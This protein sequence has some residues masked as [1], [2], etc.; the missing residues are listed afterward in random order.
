MHYVLIRYK[1]SA[2]SQE[3]DIAVT[4][5]QPRALQH[6]DALKKLYPSYQNGEFIYK[7]I[8]LIK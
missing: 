2:D 3:R 7:R 1:D 6:V 4:V 8:K 5:N